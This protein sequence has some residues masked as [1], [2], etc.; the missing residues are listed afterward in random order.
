MTMIY[1]AE[2]AAAA[3]AA[4]LGRLTAVAMQHGG[5]LLAAS[6]QLWQQWWG[7]QQCWLSLHSN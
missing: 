4:V 7:Q 2:A 3:V 6:L 1:P 5:P